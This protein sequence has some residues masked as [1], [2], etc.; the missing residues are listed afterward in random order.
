LEFSITPIDWNRIWN[1][2]IQRYRRTNDGR[3]C[4]DQWKSRESALTYWEMA[5]QT[6]QKRIEK[7]LS[8]LPLFPGCR[9]LDI[10]SGPGV[11]AIPLASRVSHVTALD[12]SDGMISVLKE[13]AIEAGLNNLDCVK[14]RW[15]MV[16][17]EK[18]L[19]G[20]YDIVLASLSLTMYD[21]HS[22]VSRMEKVCQGQ[23]ILYW[24]DGKP[25]WEGH[26]RLFEP[27]APKAPLKTVVPK[28]DLLLNV[29]RQKGINP[30]LKPF[31]YIHLDSFQC[32]DEAVRYFTE[33]FRI[34]PEHQTKA[35]KQQ[36]RDLLEARNGCF[37][38]RSEA[39]CMKIWWNV[40]GK[41]PNAG[42]KAEEKPLW[43]N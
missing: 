10:G 17:P 32:I 1:H 2:H 20:P 38:L 7:T 18:D 5:C 34:P 35:L 43:W 9:V 13:K 8:E 25:S 14:S 28:S 4:A 3:D 40:L 27:F 12:A 24:F 15:E 26:R 22:A 23:V 19:A 39:T 6:Q 36:V 30:C 37:V 41:N 29:L 16:D 11:L 33:R 31:K 42:S 21:I